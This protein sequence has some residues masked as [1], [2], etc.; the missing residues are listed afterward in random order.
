MKYILITAMLFVTLPVRSQSC[1]CEKEFLYI[2]NIVENGFSGFS[3]NVAKL[4]EAGYKKKVDELFKL[5]HNKFASDNCI[6]IISQYLNLFKSYH[7]GYWSNFDRIKIDTPFVNQ[8]P[9]FNITDKDMARLKKSRSWEG[10]YYFMRD[11]SIKIAV[12]K[13]PTALHDYVGVALESKL[14]TWKKGMIKIEG[15]LVN[16]SLMKGLYYMRNH[17]PE[18]Q[19]FN[20]WDNNNRISGDWLREGAS[21]KVEIAQNASPRK[22]SPAID[23][24]SLSANTFYI[25]MSSFGWAAKRPIDS[26]LKANEQLLNTTPNLVL[27]IR[28]NGGGGDDCW[29]PFIP[30]FYT[31]PIKMIGADALVSETTIG[32]LKKRLENKDLP[33]GEIDFYNDKLALMEK[34]KGRW[35]VSNADEIDSAFTAKAFPKKIIIIV[36]NECGSAAE[37][38]LL[39][40]RQSSKVTLVGENSIGNLDYSNVLHTPFLCFPY[41]LQFPITRSRRIDLGQGIDNVGIAPKIYLPKGKDWLEEA[42]KIAEQQ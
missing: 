40:A 1:S 23:A 27:D 20:L 36:N 14:P 35:A 22:S 39:A 3:D 21:V 12:I 42:L 18:E 16:D 34:A 29:E 15:K 5:T 32:I 28:G 6:L 26:I 2:K 9:L 37:E 33:K 19:Y 10:I 8:R 11:S 38:F 13:D 30:Y 25:K 4:T 41:T 31:N 24:R 7:L 17:R